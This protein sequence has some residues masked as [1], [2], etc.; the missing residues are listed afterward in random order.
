MIAHAD[1]Q[2]LLSALEGDPDALQTLAQYI[3]EQASLDHWTNDDVAR[4]SAR[5]ERS[6]SR[7]EQQYATVCD[8]FQTVDQR[9]EE[10]EYQHRLLHQLVE[11]LAEELVKMASK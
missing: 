10:I 8:R 3:T 6:A 4:M 1:A 11:R 9:C 7:A 2:R 5:A